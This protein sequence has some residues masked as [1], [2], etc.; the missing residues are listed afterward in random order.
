PNAAGKKI[1]VS[2]KFWNDASPDPNG[3][4]CGGACSGAKVCEPASKSCV[5]QTNCGGTCSAG[6]SCDMASCTCGP[7]IG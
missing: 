6:L 4:P 5:C 2:Y 7:G 3:D 1:A